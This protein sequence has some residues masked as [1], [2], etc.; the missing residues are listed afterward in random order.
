[1]TKRLI[2]TA[3]DQFYIAADSLVPV[4]GCSRY[5]PQVH[6]KCLEDRGVLFLRGLYTH[7]FLF[8]S[9][10]FEFLLI[11]LMGAIETEI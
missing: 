11:R 6:I 5:D 1:M 3:E 8:N 9:D 10:C 7:T 2:E 4:S